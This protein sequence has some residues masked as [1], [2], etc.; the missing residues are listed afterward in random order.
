MRARRCGKPQ[1]TQ[2]KPNKHPNKHYPSPAKPPKPQPSLN[3]ANKSL[4]RCPYPVID[5]P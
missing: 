1:F 3:P 2:Y 4:S 5:T